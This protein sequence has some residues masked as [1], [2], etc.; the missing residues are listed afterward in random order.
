MEVSQED[1]AY[2]IFSWLPAKTIFKFKLTCSSFSKFQ[3]ESHFKTK[4]FCNMLVKSDTCFFLQHDQISQRY[5]KR[6]ELHHLPKEQQ[7][8]CVPNNILTFLSNSAIVVASSNGLLLCYTINDDP[9]ELFICN[10]ITKSFF[11][12]PSPESL[13]KNHRFSNI[14]LMLNCSDD[15]SDDYLIFLFENTLDW[16]PNS[17]VCNIYHGKEGVWRTMENNFLCGGRNMKFEMSV[18]HNG[19]LH[20]I[21]DCSNYFTRFSP[22]YKPYIMAYDFVKGTST[23]IKLPREAIKG[24]HAECNMGIFNWGKVTSSNRSICLVKSTRSV[25]TIWFLKDYKSCLW[26]KILKVRVNALGLKE[27]D[28]HVTGFTIMNGK[29]LVFSTEQKIYSCGLDGETF[30][31]AEEIGSHSCGSNPYFMSY[32]NTL[33]PCGTNVQTMPC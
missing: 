26:Q 29:D 3:E 11:S 18:F 17:Y 23:I 9:V 25:F 31:M 5:Q 10:P 30:M 1:I 2:E 14:N 15:S 24:F 33:R 22:F 13:R 21:S 6:I 16:S 8:S 28:A 4:Q 27:K 7:F 32:S 20:F 12:I 19:A